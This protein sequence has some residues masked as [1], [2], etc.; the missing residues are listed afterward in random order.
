MLAPSATVEKE[1]TRLAVRS[2]E[3]AKAAFER[4][5]LR[6]RDH[7]PQ[8]QFPLKGKKNKPFWEYEITEAERLWYAV[9]EHPP[10]VIL[11]AVLRD[12]HT[13]KGVR[14]LVELRG[15]AILARVAARKMN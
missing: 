8:K 5:T 13:G 4:L 12:V 15:P 10:E 7:I 3:G 1:W 6:P 11:L 2:A 9:S 14:E